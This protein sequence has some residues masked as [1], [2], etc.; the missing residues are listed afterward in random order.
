MVLN[1]NAELSNIDISDICHKMNI[2]LNGIYMRDEMPQKLSNG[3]YIINL[4]GNDGHGTHWTCFIKDGK[5]IIYMDSFGM[6]PPQ[7]QIDI[8]HTN[9]DNI[10]YN[11]KQYQDINSVIC[12]FYCIAFF[13]YIKL[14]KND[15]TISLLEK[16]NN[17]DDKF[18]SNT[19]KNDL[20]IKKFIMQYY[21]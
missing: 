2:P 7:N 5:D 21:K 4:D 20:F 12:G 14:N 1:F 6:L 11:N 8:F 16:V 19:K 10:F 3:N 17:F 15:K 13:L 18:K 9:Q